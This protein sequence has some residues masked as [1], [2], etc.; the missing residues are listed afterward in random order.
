MNRRKELKELYKNT[1]PDMGIFIV[2]SK[3][4]KNKSYIE[5][6]Q[7]LKSKMN[8]AKFQLDLG[9]H[10]NIELQQEWKAQQESSFTIEILEILEY[11][12]DEVK[13]DY[14][15][16]LNILKMIWEEKL[17]KKGIELY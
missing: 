5:A 15:E 8:R 1:K 2:K 12:E 14:Q 11:D 4:N 16:E 7:D 13:T 6:A 17:L 9:N 3:L 10:P